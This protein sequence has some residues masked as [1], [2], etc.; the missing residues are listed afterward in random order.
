MMPLSRPPATD[1]SG[2]WQENDPE[3]QSSV[4]LI[5]FQGDFCE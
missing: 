1:L 5:L 2:L 4:T 3:K